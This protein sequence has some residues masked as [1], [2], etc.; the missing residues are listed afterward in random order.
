MLHH[1]GDN[2]EAALGVLEV[3]V[4]DSCLDDV[5]RSRHDKRGAGTGDRS[6]KVLRPRSS[7]VIGQ[8]VEVFLGCGRS[9]KQL[10]ECQMLAISLR[11]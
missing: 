3:P 10:S 7:V 8:F 1:V 4:L 9:T 6:D 5:Q 11:L 2:P